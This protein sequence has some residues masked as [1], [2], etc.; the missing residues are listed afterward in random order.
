MSTGCKVNGLGLPLT[1]SLSPQA[2]SGNGGA[3]A[4]SLLPVI[5][6]RR[7]PAGRMRGMSFERIEVD[8]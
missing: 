5:T 4:M 7:S 1:L 3:T 2:G 6:G 8:G